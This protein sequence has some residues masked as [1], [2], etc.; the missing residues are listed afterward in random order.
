MSH[1]DIS[2]E[3]IYSDFVNDPEMR[4]LIELFVSEMPVKVSRLSDLFDGLQIDELQRLAHQLKGAASGYGFGQISEAAKELEDA[5]KAQD[6]L[7]EARSQVEQLI[8]LCQRTRST[9]G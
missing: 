5:L 2:P 4:E 3:P 6:E 9:S 7:E 1:S 8:D